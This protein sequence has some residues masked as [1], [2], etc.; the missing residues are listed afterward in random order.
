VN[1]CCEARDER[2]FEEIDDER[3]CEDVDFGILEDIVEYAG[4]VFLNV[5]FFLER[6]KA[7]RSGGWTSQIFN[8]NWDQDH[9]WRQRLLIQRQQQQERH[10][11]PD[12]FFAMAESYNLGQRKSPHRNDEKVQKS[13]LV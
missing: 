10:S 1:C 5:V 2:E 7:D 11:G 13:G 9:R 8:W 12:R 3:E 4:E 6:S